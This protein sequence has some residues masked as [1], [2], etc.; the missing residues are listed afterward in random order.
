[1]AKSATVLMLRLG[2]YRSDTL[3]FIDRIEAAGGPVPDKA[4]RMALNGLKRSIANAS[5]GSLPGHL[6]VVQDSVIA[7]QLNILNTSYTG[8]N[9]GATLTSKKYVQGNGTSTYWLT[10]YNPSL[11]GAPQNAFSLFAAF[12]D[13]VTSA[14]SADMG[15]SDTVSSNGTFFNPRNGSGQAVTRINAQTTHNQAGVSNAATSFTAVRTSSAL[16]SLYVGVGFSA[17][18]GGGGLTSTGVP[19]QE[20]AIGAIG[21][22]T[23]TTF[24]TRKFSGWGAFG[25]ILTVFQAASLHRAVETY[26]ADIGART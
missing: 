18:F 22:S 3:D 1:M 26:L 13:N 11:A 4:T 10:G 7:T 25:Q 20:M 24:S 14:A 5:L 21:R 17:A 16:Y 6:H 2:K 12:Q 23:V 9:M 15:C 19:N 8:T